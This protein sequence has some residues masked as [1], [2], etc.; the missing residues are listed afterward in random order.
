M[1]L[2]ERLKQLRTD[3]ELSVAELSAQAKLS[4]PYIWQIEDGRRK[5]PSGEKLYRLAAAL[6]TTVADLMGAPAGIPQDALAD[7]PDSLRAFMR[8]RGKTLGLRR[9]DLEMLKPIHYRGKRPDNPED[10]ELIYLFLKRIL[11]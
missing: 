11:G 4:K 10:W 1:T 9:E 5:N 2:A 8:R 6:G 7:A 3:K